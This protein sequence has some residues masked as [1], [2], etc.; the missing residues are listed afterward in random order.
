MLK[1]AVRRGRI[2]EGCEC[3]LMNVPKAL[4]GPRVE[5]QAFPGIHSNKHMDG[6]ANFMKILRH[7]LLDFR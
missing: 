4:D 1:S 7:P 3:E 6:I 2:S 5:D